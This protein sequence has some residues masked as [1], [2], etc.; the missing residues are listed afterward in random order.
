MKKAGQQDIISGITFLIVV[1]F[2]YYHALQSVD[3][4]FDALGPMFVPK[5]LLTGIGFLALLLVGKGVLDHINA[6]REIGSPGIDADD[7]EQI[8]PGNPE[9]QT[10]PSTAFSGRRGVLKLAGVLLLLGLFV[11]AIN[12]RWVQFEIL[13]AIYLIASGFLIGA[14]SRKIRIA[15]IALGILLPLSIGYI[16]K[17]YLFVNLP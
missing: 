6:R 5:L 13:G 4:G 14:D 16:F 9:A 7:L 15:I 17:T 3:P 2:F 10:T 8:S 12:T 11:A 1:G